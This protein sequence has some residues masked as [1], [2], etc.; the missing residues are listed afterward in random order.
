MWE[1]TVNIREGSGVSSVGWIMDSRLGRWP[2]REPTKNNLGLQGHS[3]PAWSF[4]YQR[5]RPLAYLEEVKRDPLTE[6]KQDRPTN[7]GM[8]HAMGPRCLFPKSC[9]GT[10][11]VNG[12]AQRVLERF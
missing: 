8:I 3:E 6:P 10:E 2:S 1:L 5:L 12:A 4:G 11:Q 9:V 7:T